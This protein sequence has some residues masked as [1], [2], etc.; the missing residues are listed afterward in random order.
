MVQVPDD[1][2][3]EL[4]LDSLEVI[5]LPLPEILQVADVEV[6]HI[7]EL[8]NDVVSL[9]DVDF[10]VLRLQFV[11]ELFVED[12]LMTYEFF[13]D[14]SIGYVVHL[15]DDLLL[16]HDSVAIHLMHL[17]KEE[18][19]FLNE[20]PDDSLVLEADEF[21]YTIEVGDHFFFG[22][23]DQI[24]EFVEGVGLLVLFLQVLVPVLHSF[25]EDSVDLFLLALL[26]D[27]AALQD[28]LQHEGL[29]WVAKLGHGQLLGVVFAGEELFDSADELGVFVPLRAEE[30][31]ELAFLLD[32]VGVL[33]VHLAEEG[34]QVFLEVVEQF[35]E[36][37]LHQA[38]SH[39]KFEHA[40]D[41]VYIVLVLL[42]VFVEVVKR[43]AVRIP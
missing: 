3:I 39:I 19:Q 1:F 8:G 6:V 43:V 5:V 36:E 17:N 23:V 15:L 22:I 2:L 26:E 28:V 18:N 10:E 4:P 21:Q 32:E 20:S 27:V 24:H 31:V 33:E 12:L 13:S 34:L 42:H 16:G 41:L 29:V 37:Y 11:V 30:L 7:F 35:V 9:I 38:S 25:L 40:L 14:Q